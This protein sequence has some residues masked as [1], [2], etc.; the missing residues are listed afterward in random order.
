MRFDDIVKSVGEFGLYQKRVYALLCL[1]CMSCGIQVMLSVFTLGVPEHRCAV[2]GL[3]NDTYTIASDEHAQIVNASIPLDDSAG[4]PGSFSRCSIWI[5]DETTGQFTERTCRK[6]VY[7]DSV[8]RSTIVSKFDLVCEHKIARSH[9]RMI[10]MSGLLIGAIG[11]GILA[12]TIG[13]KMALMAMIALQSVSAIGV[14]F[15]ESFVAY[16]ILRFITGV[17]IS[18]LFL[19]VFVL[20]MELVG[21]SKRMFVGVL[22]NIFWSLGVMLLGSIAYFI[23]DWNYLQMA[24]SFPS[25][26][27]L[28]YWW[29]IPESPRW[30]LARGRDEEAETVI[31][32]AARVNGVTIPEKIFDDITFDEAYR[33]ESICRIFTAPKYFLRLVILCYNW[34]AAAMV[35]YGLSLNSGNLA[36]NIYINFEL[37]G[38]VEIVAYIICL[39]LLNSVGR[40]IVHITCMIV[41]GGACLSAIFVVLFASECLQW[42]NIVLALIGKCGAAAAFAIVYIYSAELF[43]TVLRNSLMGVACLFARLGGMISPYIADLSSIV[44]SEFGQAI[45]LIVFGSSTIIGGLLCIMLPE[46]LNR[47]LPETLEDAINL[48]RHDNQSNRKQR[49]GMQE[50]S[51]HLTGKECKPLTQNADGLQSNVVKETTFSD[52]IAGDKTKQLVYV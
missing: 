22:V 17:S 47:H 9:A 50:C 46:T 32:H 5:L 13:R 19:A 23:R 38:V 25:L 34:L 15:T 20:G 28:C 26:L 42:I 27:L 1:A 31:R 43:P 37:M 45:P 44:E 24:L 49:E 8:F 33:R 18:G 12:D 48:G 6:W 11:T 4:G 35:F 41:G 51:K 2:P 3:A 21:P 16:V 10:L 30:L 52:D 36:G 40:K 7:D 29:F 39:T 14:A